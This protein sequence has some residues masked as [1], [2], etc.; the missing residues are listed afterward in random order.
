MVFMA[1]SMLVMIV[2]SMLMAGAS[3]MTNSSILASRPTGLSV[4]V[5]MMMAGVDMSLSMAMR[6]G[7]IYDRCLR[8]V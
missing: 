8:P 6:R 7:L 2:M 1:M 4:R 5:V 3:I